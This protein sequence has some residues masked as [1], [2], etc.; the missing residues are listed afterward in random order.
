MVRCGCRPSQRRAEHFIVMADGAVI[1]SRA[2][3]DLIFISQAQLM[4]DF[5][6]LLFTPT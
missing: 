4:H 3:R 2:L 5:I 6:T 1:P